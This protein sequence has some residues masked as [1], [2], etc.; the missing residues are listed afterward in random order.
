MISEGSFLFRNNFKGGLFLPE[1]IFGGRHF[2][3]GQ[4]I[5][6]LL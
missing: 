1:D 6:D 5:T 4:E 2:P 3:Y